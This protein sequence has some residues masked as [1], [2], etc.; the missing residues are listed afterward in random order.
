M[1]SGRFTV[2]LS[3]TYNLMTTS[4]K[5]QNWSLLALII[6]FLIIAGT[7][8]YYPKWKMSKTEATISWDVSGYYFYLPALFIYKDLTKVDFR[9]SVVQHYQ[10][11]SGAYQAYELENGNRVMKYSAGM[12]LQY[13]PFFTLS[14]IVA[15]TSDY[16]ADGFS[17]PYQVGI[18]FGS[19]LVAFIGL[20]FLRRNLL[21]YF[22]DAVTGVTILLIVVASNYLNYSAIDNAMTHNWLFT[23]Y[24][25]LI[26]QTIKFYKRP[27]S[28]QGVTIGATVGL[29]ALTRPTEIIA[30]ILPLL[31][32]IK[33]RK[34]FED[35]L[36]FFLDFSRGGKYFLFAGFGVAVLG[37]IQPLYWKFVAGEWLVYS[38]QDQGFSWLTPH[39]IDGF[40]SGKGGWL[41]YSPIML[42]P[43][44]GLRTLLLRHRQLFLATTIFTGLF[45]YITF[46]WDIWWYG[47]SLG[48]RAMVQ[49]YAI[50]A[51]PF[52]GLVEW[53]KEKKI[54]S[55]LLLVF[56]IG[57]IYY[58]IWLTHQAHR[59]G[60]F[61]SEQMTLP[62]LK[63]IF[64]RNELPSKETIK[65]LDTQEL[66]PGTPKIVE[67]L[68]FLD[69]ESDTV[70]HNCPIPPIEGDRSLCLSAQEPFSPPVQIHSKEIKTPWIRVQGEFRCQDKEW[71]F[72][73]MSQ[74]MV[75]FK[76]GDKEIQTRFIRLFRLLQPNST[77]NI[78]LDVPVPK[79][80]YDFL[81]V[82]F[83]Q[84]H[85]DKPLAIDQLQITAIE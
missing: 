56:S 60:L 64:L 34:D 20:I 16:P 45:I 17:L 33:N 15:S 76:R 7:H 38:Y 77:Q 31:W 79:Q 84:A 58:N 85:S 9:D 48:Q 39:L 66:Y 40:F 44:L 73:R 51:F 65:L 13:L 61:I 28:W 69:F 12:A 62:Y 27:S 71:E 10:M 21:Q 19:L 59:G 54:P 8:A 53:V 18:S 74:L 47:G 1:A 50:L 63:A 81:E 67:D 23:L 26:W 4:S 72:W 37:G 25:I 68:V 70:D 83:W 57:C 52:A 42:L 35:R 32:G 78:Y 41:V 30:L 43:L 3:I 14:H 11:S 29:M 2:F 49:S 80:P 36:S 55:I 82:Q 6:S 24:T 75:K 22:S 5:N 46:A